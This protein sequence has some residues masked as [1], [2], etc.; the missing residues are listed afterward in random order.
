MDMILNT[1]RRGTRIGYKAGALKYA[2]KFTT[3]EFVAIF[4]AD[5]IP[6]EWFLK[7]AIPY[8]AKSNIGLIQCRWGHL[9]ENYSALTQ[10]QALSLDF[11]FLIEQRG[12]KQFTFVY[13]F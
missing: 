10:A 8:F 5:F 9:N 3:T 2:M 1:C 11:H 7:K 6:P 4:D 12:K 13:E